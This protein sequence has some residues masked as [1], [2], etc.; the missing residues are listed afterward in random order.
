MFFFEIS[1]LVS[2]H[3]WWNAQY[4]YK[5]PM[6]SRNPLVALGVSDRSRCGG[7]FND[8]HFDGRGD[9][10][11]RSCHGEFLEKILHGEFYK[12]LVH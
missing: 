12:G 5:T 3:E 7:M 2:I 9:L 8:V 6:C 1:S 11:Q 4:F 10:V